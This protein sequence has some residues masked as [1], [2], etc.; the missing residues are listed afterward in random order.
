MPLRHLSQSGKI[1]RLRRRELALRQVPFLLTALFFASVAICCRAEAPS[2]AATAWFA[3]YTHA[4]EARLDQQHEVASEFIPGLANPAIMARLRKGKPIVEDKTPPDQRVDGALLHDWRG[5][6]F[7]PGATAADCERLLKD[8]SAYPKDYAPEI[9][10]AAII[11]HHSNRYNVKI[12]LQQKHVITVVLD[13][14]YDV[15]FKQ[16]DAQHGYSMSRSTRVAEI[17]DPGTPEEHS[18]PVAEEHGFLWRVNVYWSWEQRD[19]GVYLRMETVTL[20]RA[21]PNGLGW[22]MGSYLKKAPRDSLEFTL[23]ATRKVLRR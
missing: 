22:L 10:S 16:L 6:M 9:L 7:V 18:L 13:T 23:R 3:A 4:L 20:T 15:V 11:N 8:Y 5:T 14:T 2:P 12:R 17:A 1:R 21:V 19:G